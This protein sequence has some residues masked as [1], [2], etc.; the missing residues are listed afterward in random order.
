NSLS[1]T[2]PSEY[3]SLSN[4]LDLELHENSLS[5]TVPSELISLS[6]LEYLWLDGTMGDYD[7]QGG[8][9]NNTIHGDDG[10]DR[11]YGNGGKDT[12]YGGPGDDLLN[13][14]GGNDI[15]YGGPGDDLLNGNGGNDALYGNDGADTFV[16]AWG[17]GADI[18]HDFSVGTDKFQL[19]E[20]LHFG[21]KSKNLDIVS[22][23]GSI[24]IE[25]YGEVL[26]EL[27]GI[28]YEDIRDVSNFVELP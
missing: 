3:G 20:G 4:L 17:M 5:G 23:E 22:S 12:L 16:L 1:G 7:F 6:N 14:N 26:A 8:A 11:L 27:P 28:A 25:A 24:Y 13:G 10:S 15:L 19:E 18:I 9:G 2:L 21:G